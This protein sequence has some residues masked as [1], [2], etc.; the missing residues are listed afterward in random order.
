MAMTKERIGEIAFAGLK[1]RT[2]NELS[3]RDLD[4]VTRDVGN[5]L[6]DKEMVDINTT[7]EELH[8]FV[9]LMLREIFEHQLAKLK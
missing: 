2:R 9:E 3:L 1:I 6:K 7:R 8:E 5:L 4:N